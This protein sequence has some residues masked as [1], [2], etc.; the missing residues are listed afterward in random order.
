MLHGE[1]A[2][3]IKFEKMRFVGNKIHRE[4]E[5]ERESME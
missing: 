2:L 1:N 5:R 3:T 4:R